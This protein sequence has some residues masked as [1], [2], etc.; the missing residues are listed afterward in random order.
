MQDRRT[1]LGL[2][3]S[4]G[5]LLFLVFYMGGVAWSY[6]IE[7]PIALIP[8]YMAGSLVGP[9]LAVRLAGREG[10]GST[11]LASFLPV[12]VGSGAAALYYFLQDRRGVASTPSPEVLS[13]FPALLFPVGLALAFL[14][15]WFARKQLEPTQP[16]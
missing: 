11:P 10:F 12:L 7:N 1:R 2:A 5:C 15:R 6:W 13:V 8:T 16:R 14:A 4:L 9:Y 3:Q